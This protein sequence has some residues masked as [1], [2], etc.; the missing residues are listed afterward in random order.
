[1]DVLEYIHY[2]FFYKKARSQLLGKTWRETEADNTGTLAHTRLQTH[3][4]VHNT[5]VLA[6]TSIHSLNHR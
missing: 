6:H 5:G 1:M 3:T 4:H 2:T